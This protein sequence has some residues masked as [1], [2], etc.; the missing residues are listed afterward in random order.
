MI[1]WI[2]AGA[3]LIVI[4]GTVVYFWDWVRTAITNWLHRYGYARSQLMN[5]FIK[6]DRVIVGIRARA[7]ILVQISGSTT[8]TKVTE[9]EINISDLPEDVRRQLRLTGQATVHY[10]Y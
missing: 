7:Q 4:G 10:S 8:Q 9:E 5:A 1:E 6:I 3:L 2:L